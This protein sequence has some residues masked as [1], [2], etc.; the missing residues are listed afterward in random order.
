LWQ[1]I[2][3]CEKGVNRSERGYLAK[4]IFGAR[5][6]LLTNLAERKEEVDF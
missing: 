6:N 2:R 5:E 1:G 3:G 4:R